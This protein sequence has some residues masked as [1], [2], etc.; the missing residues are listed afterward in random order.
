MIGNFGKWD[1]EL[2]K[3]NITG[4]VN[5]GKVAEEVWHE[6]SSD[7]E[8]LAIESDRCIAEFLKKPI[9]EV[10]G[11]TNDDFPMGVDREA[12]V[13]QRVNQQFFRASVLAAYDLSCCMTGF[14]IPEMLVASHIVPWRID[15]KNRLNPRNGLCLNP[16]HDKA[17][18]LGYISVANDFRI[19]V[20][21]KIREWEANPTTKAWISDMNGKQLILPDKFM[22]D[23]AFLEF[24][25]TSIFK[26]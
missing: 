17:F 8:K 2:K 18:D 25:R 9:E 5:A 10:V 11:I 13:R 1:P 6:F 16:F 24:H 7:W 14:N 23:E 26:R 15:Q 20:T 3:R 22:P 12:V 21:P 19:L 4:L